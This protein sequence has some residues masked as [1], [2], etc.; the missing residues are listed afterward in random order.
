MRALRLLISW[1]LLVSSIIMGAT[2]LLADWWGLSQVRL[3]IWSGYAFLVAGTAHVILNWR[4]LFSLARLRWLPRTRAERP[5]KIRE[6]VMVERRAF[7]RG[8]GLGVLGGLISAYLLPMLFNVR[9]RV[10]DLSRAYHEWSS[11]TLRGVLWSGLRWGRQ[12][13]Q[14]KTYPEAPRIPLPTP[15]PM[16]MRLD[17]AL[18]RRRS[19]RDYV[20]RPIPLEHLSA[21]LHAAQGITEPTY[22]KRAAPSAGAL[23]PIE[24]YA[25]VHN[26]QGLEPG[27]YHYAVREHA[28]ERIAEGNKRR[29]IAVACLDQEHAATAGVVFVLTAIFQRERWKYQGRAYRYILQETG[30]IG[31]NIYLA[32]TA[33]GL[34]CCAI[35]AFYDDALNRMLGVDGVE[36]AALYVLT[37]GVPVS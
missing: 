24:V 37:V 31:E 34:G 7:L 18:E 8:V 33:L 12:P 30:H 28:L 23:Y 11:I 35:G 14:Y 17:E 13:A 22:P 9:P 2:G 15:H 27:I 20:N 32:A 21:L 3:H 1:A 29:E 26:V 25:V 4:G 16:T 5:A 10:D 36:E 6:G 19:I